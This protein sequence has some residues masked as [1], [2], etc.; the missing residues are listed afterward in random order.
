MPF[1]KLLIINELDFYG[2]RFG[3]IEWFNRNT[4]IPFCNTLLRTILDAKFTNEV[5]TPIRS[6]AKKVAESSQFSQ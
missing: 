5:I 4:L 3:I 6:T 2:D 1:R